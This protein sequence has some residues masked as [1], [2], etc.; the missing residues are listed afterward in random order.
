[1]GVMNLEMKRTGGGANSGGR[2]EINTKG[3]G[4]SRDK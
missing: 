4:W 1:M 3:E 2:W